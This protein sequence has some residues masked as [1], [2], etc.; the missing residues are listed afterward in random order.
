MRGT[1]GSPQG[2]S[3]EHAGSKHRC[4]GLSKGDPGSY[5]K[6]SRAFGY[7]IYPAPF[8]VECSA[9]PISPGCCKGSG[10]SC[11]KAW[12]SWRSSSRR[13]RR[14][15]GS[16]CFR[17]LSATCAGEAGREAPVVTAWRRFHFGC[18]GPPRSIQRHVL[19]AGATD[20]MI[21]VMLGIRES[22]R[23]APAASEGDARS[24]R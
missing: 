18:G 4:R 1:D 5:R 14:G 24:E 11:R 19:V 15:R 17:R 9:G 6:T 2:P 8:S 13:W 7:G 23:T 22:G 10:K 16:L 3:G 20:S 12:T 21:P